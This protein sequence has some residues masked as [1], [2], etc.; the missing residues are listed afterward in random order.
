MV[1]D[2]DADSDA[3][4]KEELINCSKELTVKEEQE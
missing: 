1:L 4:I 2:R 3:E